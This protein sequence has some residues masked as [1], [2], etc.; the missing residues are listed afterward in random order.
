MD[1]LEGEEALVEE[2]TQR[3]ALIAVYL[4]SDCSSNTTSLP[5]VPATISF[6]PWLSLSLRNTK[7]EQCLFS[8][9]LLLLVFLMTATK[10]KKKEKSPRSIG[11][12]ILL[13][14]N[15]EIEHFAI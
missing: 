1:S 6:I 14:K 2:E 7:Q 4:P 5:P 9:K 13:F 11:S 15:A 10:K 8:P 12:M 3:T